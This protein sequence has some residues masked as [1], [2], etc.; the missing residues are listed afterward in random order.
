MEELRF[1]K[2]RPSLTYMLQQ[3]GTRRDV[4]SSYRVSKTAGNPELTTGSTHKPG[5]GEFKFWA[6]RDTRDKS[7]PGLRRN[8]PA[9]ILLAFPSGFPG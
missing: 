1:A 9:F 2:W 4:L 7:P 6:I 5:N 8:C 3:D